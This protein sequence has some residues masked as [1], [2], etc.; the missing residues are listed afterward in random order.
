MLHVEYNDDINVALVRLQ[1]CEI[2]ENNVFFYLQAAH[3]IR[4]KASTSRADASKLRDETEK[5]SCKFVIG[6]RNCLTVHDINKVVAF[7][8]K[9]EYLHIIANRNLHNGVLLVPL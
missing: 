2:V 7:G 9:L 4:K 8:V 1:I 3:E 5:L 6:L